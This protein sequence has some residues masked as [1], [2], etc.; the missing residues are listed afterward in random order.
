MASD[1]LIYNDNYQKILILS[2]GH[3]EF[4]EKIS[5][6]TYRMVFHYLIRTPTFYTNPMRGLETIFKKL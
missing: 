2:N 5:N 6:L 4:G 3:G 1:Y